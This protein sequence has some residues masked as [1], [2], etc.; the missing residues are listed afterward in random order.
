MLRPLLG[1]V[2]VHPH[3]AYRV[4]HAMSCVLGAG[5]STL[6]MTSAVV[7]VLSLVLNVSGLDFDDRAADISRL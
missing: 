2:R 4:F 7:M 5:A 3:A 1:P 6:N